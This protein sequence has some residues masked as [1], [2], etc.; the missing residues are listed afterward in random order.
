MKTHAS[1]TFLLLLSGCFYPTQAPAQSLPSVPDSPEPILHISS[2]LV[3]VEVEALG[4]NNHPV[5][6]LK[7]QDFQIFDNDRPVSIKTFDT[8]TETRPLALWFVVQCN[9]H[10]WETHGS[11]LFSGQIERFHPALDHLDKRDRVA[12]AAWCDDGE[13]QIDLPPTDDIGRAV[14]S[15]E[16]ALAPRPNTP[17][18]NRS[19]EL[20][21]QKTLQL[22]VDSTR[23]MPSDLVPV[24]VFLYGDYSAMP[25]PEADQF[26]DQLLA[27]SAMAFGLRDRRSPRYFSFMSPG[28]QGSIANY[29]A[30]QTGGEYFW[31]TPETY[32]SGLEEILEQ[33]HARYE[34]GF[35]PSALDGKRHKLQVKL[36]DHSDTSI[37]GVRL[38]YRAA[39]VS[40]PHPES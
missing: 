20:A 40:V 10:G 13:A 34:L 5:N 11:G 33:L 23:S 4:A 32:A 15:L 2:D 24:I 39:Y 12:V 26:I 21:L 35:K 29:I 38:R 30:A 8:G 3:L 22:I 25:R 28:E 9:M 27:T 1:L 37:A 18:H 7:R 17:S 31:V 19:G 14:P 6:T 16:Q 36:T